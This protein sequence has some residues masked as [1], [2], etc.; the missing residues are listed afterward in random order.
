MVICVILY[1]GF[2]ERGGGKDDFRTEDRE[3]YKRLII[4]IHYRLAVTS[5]LIGNT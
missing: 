3:I 2:R 1:N 4:S 5:G